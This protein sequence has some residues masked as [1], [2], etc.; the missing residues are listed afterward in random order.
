MKA[1]GPGRQQQ[2][3]CKYPTL[4]TPRA[5]KELFARPLRGGPKQGLS[6]RVSLL[7]MLRPAAKTT[8]YLSHNFIHPQLLTGT[9]TDFL[10][11]L[12]TPCNDALLRRLATPWYDASLRLS[13]APC[14]DA[15]LRRPPCNDASLR[16]STTPCFASPRRL[17]TMPRYASLLSTT[18]CS[19]ASLR[20]LATPCN[21]AS[22]RLSL[23]RLASPCFA[24]LRRLVTM[25]RHDRLAPLSLASCTPPCSPLFPLPGPRVGPAGPAV[26]AAAGRPVGGRASASA[27][28]HQVGLRHDL[29]AALGARL[30]RAQ[31]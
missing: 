19:D 26:P 21:D 31:G 13:T 27:G 25:P 8:A 30:R 11:R 6:R 17:V 12:V 18:P 1:T 28:A 16:L 29:Q 4:F 24:S 22:L 14:S 9:A 5:H 23:R 15:S 7:T 2:P 20:R 3:S 10:L